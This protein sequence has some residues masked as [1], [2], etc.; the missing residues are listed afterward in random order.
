MAD[1]C[2]FQLL[3]YFTIERWRLDVSSRRERDLSV[4]STDGITHVDYVAD[5]IDTAGD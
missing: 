5:V 1:D 3:L 2:E 4:S